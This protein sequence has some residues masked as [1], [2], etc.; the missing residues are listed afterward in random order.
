VLDVIRKRRSIR[1][2]LAD[3]VE[4]E[5]L[6]EILKAA[7]FSPT[8]RGRRPWEFIVVKNDVMKKAL[9]EASP[10]A[11]FVKDAP[12]TII[13][14]YDTDMGIR[15]REDASISAAHIHLEVV[16]QGLGTCFVQVADAAEGIHGNAEDYVK[17]LLK[18]PDRYRV[19]CMM[20]VGYPAK[21]LPEH[22]DSE[23]DKAKIHREKF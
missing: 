18:I 13:I 15:F 2:Y 1:S 6:S 3:D 8:S 4:D 20:P 23:F 22:S 16:N 11:S 10:Y 21:E 17:E 14:C 19:Q 7:M 5:K 12:V 9:S